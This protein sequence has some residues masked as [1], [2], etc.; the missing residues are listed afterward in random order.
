MHPKSPMFRG[1]PNFLKSRAVNLGERGRRW[2]PC[3]TSRWREPLSAQQA[4]PLP[5]EPSEQVVRKINLLQ[6]T[7]SLRV[8]IFLTL[9]G[10]MNLRL[11]GWVQPVPNERGGL[12]PRT[13]FESLRNKV[14][15]V[16]EPD[17]GPPTPC[18]NYGYSEGGVPPQRR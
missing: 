18:P 2:T 15:S 16:V 13:R 11:P 5:K 14:E 1:K 17:L 12:R 4:E 7:S 10:R 8:F 3:E 6:L 9:F